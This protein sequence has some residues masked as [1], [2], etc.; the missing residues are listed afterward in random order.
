MP[1]AG[2]SQSLSTTASAGGA[3]SVTFRPSAPGEVWTV[4]LLTATSLSATITVTRNQ[5]QVIDTTT[6]D[7]RPA[8]TSDSVYTLGQGETLVVTWAGAPPGVQLVATL[9]GTIST[10][11]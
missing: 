8:V 10:A 6:A 4:E 5:T 9:T 11:G 7:P 3:G 1:T 2:L